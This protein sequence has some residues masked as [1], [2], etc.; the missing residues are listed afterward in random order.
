MWEGQP[1]NDHKTLKKT[2]GDRLAFTIHLDPAVAENPDATEGEL[3]QEVRRSID[4][5]GENGGM[6]LFSMGATPAATEIIARETFDYSRKK[7]GKI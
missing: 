6:V 1:M 7:F 2:V 4:T 3:V 5:Y